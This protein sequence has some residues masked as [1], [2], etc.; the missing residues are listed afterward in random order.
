MFKESK[1]SIKKDRE[2]HSWPMVARNSMTEQG[3]AVIDMMDAA[4]YN[5]LV[6]PRVDGIRS[7]VNIDDIDKN[8]SKKPMLKILEK[9]PTRRAK[10]IIFVSCSFVTKHIKQR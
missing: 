2:H 9:I 1:S 8:V 3:R 5:A 6:L 4:F 7:L 10:N